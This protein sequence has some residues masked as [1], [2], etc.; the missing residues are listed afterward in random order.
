MLAH[1]S[2]RENV[3]NTNPNLIGYCS[4]WVAEYVDYD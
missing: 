2:E 3:K 4:R 1:K